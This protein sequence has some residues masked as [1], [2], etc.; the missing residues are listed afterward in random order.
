MFKLLSHIV[1][2]LT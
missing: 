1:F 2:K